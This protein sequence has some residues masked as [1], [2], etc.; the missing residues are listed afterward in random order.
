MKTFLPQFTSRASVLTLLLL[1]FNQAAEGHY[2]FPFVIVNGVVSERWEYIRPTTE[3][4]PNFDYSGPPSMCGFNGTRPLFPIKTI[5]I[6]AGSMIGF[7]SSGQTGFV[8][9]EWKSTEPWYPTFFM[10]HDGPATAYLSK[11][12]GDL[13]EYEGGGDWFKIAAVGASDGMNWDYRQANQ[14]NQM[15]FTIPKSTPPGKYLMRVEHLNIMTFYKSTQ[16]YVNCAHVEISGPGGGNPGP[17][18]KFPGAF[19][20]KDAG[21]W[22]P[23]LLDSPDVPLDQ[24]KNWQGAGP[25]VWK[26]EV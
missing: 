19:D 21:I 23:N 1:Q 17:M 10:Y 11:A 20:A 18:T 13:D 14:V 3:F 8:T 12:P 25:K 4:G 9:E 5:K 15:N 26:P 7:G 16:M 24:L 22:L 6:E 2:G